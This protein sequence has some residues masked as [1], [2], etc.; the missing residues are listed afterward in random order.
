VTEKRNTAG[1]R[2]RELLGGVLL[3]AS[4]ANLLAF[5]VHGLALGG[6]AGNGKREGERFFVGDHGTFTE[7]TE[8]QWRRLWRHELSLYGTVPLGVIAGFV[9]QQS[10]NQRARERRLSRN[11][12]PSGDPSENG[13]S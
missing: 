12:L 6:S 5:F 11:T 13:E 4:V 2:W 3:A 7:V 8:L 9:L 1:Q 10:E